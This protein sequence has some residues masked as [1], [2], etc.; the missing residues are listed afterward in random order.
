MLK[1]LTL[2]AHLPFRS[3][4]NEAPGSKGFLAFEYDRFACFELNRDCR[5]NSARR[6]LV[7]HWGASLRLDMVD[8][9]HRPFTDPLR[10]GFQ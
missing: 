6:R 10:A 5:K 7:L 4:R 9:I 8:K 2:V 3:G 1:Q